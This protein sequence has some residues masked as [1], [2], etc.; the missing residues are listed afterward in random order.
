MWRCPK[1]HR[2]IT[3]IH[4]GFYTL[5]RWHNPTSRTHDP[6]RKESSAT[7]WHPW[8]TVGMIFM[9][10]KEHVV[11]G[12]QGWCLIMQ[13]QLFKAREQCGVINFSFLLL[14]EITLIPLLLLTR[15]WRVLVDTNPIYLRSPNKPFLSFSRILSP[16]LLYHIQTPTPL[17]T[18][19]SVSPFFRA[20]HYRKAQNRH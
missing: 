9:S 8:I 7:S 18:N 6:I 14:F 10:W 15:L 1:T 11:V 16:E 19:L 20:L 5:H 12:D 3:C 4:P 2:I 13:A 17:C